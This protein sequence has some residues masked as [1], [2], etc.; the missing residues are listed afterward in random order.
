MTEGNHEGVGAWP[1]SGVRRGDTAGDS[2]VPEHRAGAGRRAGSRPRGRGGGPRARGGGAETRSGQPAGDDRRGVRPGQ[3]G[4]PA[5]RY[6]ARTGTRG[7]GSHGGAVRARPETA[8]RGAV[9]AVAPAAVRQCRG[10]HRERADQLARALDSL[11]AQDHP[12]F[13]IVVVDNAP[14]T[15]ET[16]EL[17][18]RK[19]GERVRYVCEP[20]PGLAIAHNRGLA[21]VR[22]AVVAFTD[23]DVVADPRWLTELT[24]PFAADPRLGCATGLI[25][26]ARLRTPPGPPGEPRRLREGVH[27]AGRT[28]PSTARRRAAV[29]V[30]RGPV[31]LRRQHGLRTDV[32]RAVG[33]FGPRDRSGHARGAATTST[34]SSASS[35]RGGGCATPRTH[36]SGTTTGRPGGTWRPG[37]TA[38]AR[39]SPRISRRSW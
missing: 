14:V 35:P 3:T 5:R 13:E 12:D 36:W 38:T 28:T 34:A 16:R 27:P 15:E 7:R 23:D 11:L 20:V 8:A 1:V 21:V 32:L 30:H 22:G 2:R 6:R 19:C 26:P 18:E 4:G 17:V 25:L 31:R 33:G 24:A 39:A 10:R 29:P 37:P 9:R